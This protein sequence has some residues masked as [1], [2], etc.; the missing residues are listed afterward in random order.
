MR[1]KVYKRTITEETFAFFKVSLQEKGSVITF[2][3]IL[4]KRSL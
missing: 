3:N 1:E 4:S 2:R